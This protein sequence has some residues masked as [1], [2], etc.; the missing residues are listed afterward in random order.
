MQARTLIMR[1]AL[2]LIL[3]A[4][5]SDLDAYARNKNN[6]QAPPAQSTTEDPGCHDCIA[7][8]ATLFATGN[9]VDAAALLQSWRQKCPKNAQLRILLSTILIRT[10]TQSV[11]AESVAR[12]A[13][14]LAPKSLTAHMQYALTSMLNGKTVQ[15]TQQFEAVVQLEPSNYEAWSA[16][17]SLYSQLHEDEKSQAAQQKAAALEPSVQTVR[18][19]QLRNLARSS[20][21]G[22]L[23]A[24]L[25]QL[26]STNDNEPEA[27]SLIAQ[28][29]G[30]LGA[31]DAAVTA[32]DRVL[33]AYP[34]SASAIKSKA[35]A[36]LFLDQPESA[37]SLATDLLRQD[38]TAAE[39]YAV[40]SIAAALLGRLNESREDLE[41]AQRLQP[42]LALTNLAAAHRA[43]QEGRLKDA[44]VAAQAA[45]QTQSAS[46]IAHLYLCR[47]Y[48]KERKLNEALAETREAARGP[49]LQSS[50]LALESQI[51]LLLGDK[52]EI[53]NAEELAQRCAR[54][55]PDQSDCL[56]AG[57]AIALH[58]NRAELARDKA[59][60][61][62]AKEAGNADALYLLSQVEQLK[63]NTAEQT[64]L[65][66]RCLT[67]APADADVCLA[68]GK[69]RLA[70]GDAD[71]SQSLLEKTLTARPDNAEAN[72]YLAQA[73]EHKGDRDQS[74]K[75]YQLSLSLGIAG[76]ERA[77]ATESLKRLQS[78]TIQP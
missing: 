26:I 57:A 61:V 43:L 52:D 50:S 7:K 65:L 49:S 3:A 10:R 25:K 69:L 13:V 60:R 51:R 22:A 36:Q 47:I 46:P 73:L 44:S 35:I 76:Q 5:A 37:A 53:A 63:G 8:A 62:L 12:E 20:K 68:L 58:D 33:I 15:A 19:R 42:R 29:A 16:L 72:F 75:F 54:T 40:N 64:K 38:K 56:L 23:S 14:E 17:G 66:E 28:E 45:L 11:E 77:S 1:G 41:T 9:S 24:E 74:I 18:L 48:L 39:M 59:S 70:A 31:Y 27:L 32:A 71:R 67:M 34:Q 30:E 2:F 6:L 4:L 21:P 55:N 78:A